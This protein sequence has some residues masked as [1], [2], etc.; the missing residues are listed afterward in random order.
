M[1][2]L[3][4]KVGDPLGAALG[5]VGPDTSATIAMLIIGFHA[6]GLDI[7]PFRADAYRA[8]ATESLDRG[9][10]TRLQQIIGGVSQESHA[11]HTPVS[12]LSHQRVTFETEEK[13]TEEPVLDFGFASDDDDL[14]MGASV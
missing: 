11:Y 10:A 2:H 1:K 6:V 8:L 4:V 12:P 13:S 5:G 7:A 3:S 9:I 14:D